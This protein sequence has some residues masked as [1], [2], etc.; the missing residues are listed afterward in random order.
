MRYKYPKRK[1]GVAG[2]DFA[3]PYVKLRAAEMDVNGFLPNS[4]KLEFREAH[5]LLAWKMEHSNWD[6]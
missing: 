4:D 1:W 2:V 5:V 6:Y 3:C